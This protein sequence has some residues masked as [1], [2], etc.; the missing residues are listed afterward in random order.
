MRGVKIPVLTVG[1]RTVQNSMRLK[2]G[3]YSINSQYIYL[4]KFE[5]FVQS[6]VEY[7]VIK[8]LMKGQL[9]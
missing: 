9:Y 8:G 4:K 1:I 5:K 7:V 3:P 6:F 2:W